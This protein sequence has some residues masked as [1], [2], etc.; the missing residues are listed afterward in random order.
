[1]TQEQVIQM[2]GKSAIKE[3]K[4]DDPQQLTLLTVPKPHAAFEMYSL[5]FSPKEGLLKL[6]AYGKDI[7]TNGF[8]EAVRDAFM[9]IRDAVANTYGQPE[10]LD[11][12]RSGS[13][14]HEPE[15]WMMGLL[16]DERTLDA[17]WKKE[18][19]NGICDIDLEAK[20]MSTEKG[21]LVLSYEFDGWSQY[22]DGVK[23][24]QTTVF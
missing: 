11:F 15:Y 3:T 17:F 6:T 23:K 10:T 13:L 22:L 1:M 16:K 24:K 12:V 7:R 21:F 19:P 9:E 20:A 2:V 18:I 8:G 14:W 5:L 4:G